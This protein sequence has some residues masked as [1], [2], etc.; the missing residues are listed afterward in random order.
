M[1]KILGLILG[2]VLFPPFGAI[3]GFFLGAVIDANSK[4]FNSY[5]AGRSSNRFTDNSLIDAFPLFAA[6]IVNADGIDRLSILNVKNIAVQVFGTQPAKIIM[7]NF[8]RYIESGY[9]RSQVDEYCSIVYNEVDLSVRYNFVNVL[10]SIIKSRGIFSQNEINVLTRIAEAIGVSINQFGGGY[11]RTYNYE[12]SYNT[13][14][15]TGNPYQQPVKDYYEV[16]GM[17]KTASDEELKKQ[18]RTL[19]KKYHPDKS[20]N[21]PENEQKEHEAKMKEIIG[22]YEEIKKERG[23]K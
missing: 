11:N 12:Y 21:L 6:E 19:C 10:F 20:S 23:I 4:I 18:Y 9:S 3:I 16:L 7:E 8:K 14:Y 15:N 2:F 5:N 17:P 13:G 22:A 1:G